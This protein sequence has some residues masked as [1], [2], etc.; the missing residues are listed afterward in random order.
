MGESKKN[1]DL[2][3]ERNDRCVPISRKIVEIISKK[4][5]LALGSN[6]S[7]ID[8]IECYEPIYKEVIELFLE[9]DIK[10]KE[11]DFILDLVVQPL[12]FI[13]DMMKISLGT[14]KGFAEAHLWG[15]D[16]DLDAD[17]LSWK[18]LDEVVKAFN[19]K[20]YPKKEE[21]EAKK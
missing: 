5:N 15:L 7:D 10:V 6:V 8:R 14:N 16:D 20:R 12:E 2:E 1:R 3:Q 17:N 4:K 19:A 21:K 11:A 18:K 13:R 9:E